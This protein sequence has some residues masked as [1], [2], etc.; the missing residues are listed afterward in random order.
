MRFKRD[1]PWQV[2]YIAVPVLII[3]GC[4]QGEVP[5]AG[6]GCERP[7]PGGAQG[8]PQLRQRS[9]ACR[10]GAKPRLLPAAVHHQPLQAGQRVQSAPGGALADRRPR[11]VVFGAARG[12]YELRE[13]RQRRK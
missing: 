9:E 13:A 1:Q 11:R 3:L 5:Q 7:A 8:R 2:R 6:G 4:Q 10:G 12:D